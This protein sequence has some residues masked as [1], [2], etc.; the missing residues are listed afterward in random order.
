MKIKH[1]LF[2][3]VWRKANQFKIMVVA[4]I[5]LLVV[6]FMLYNALI[7]DNFIYAWFDLGIIGWAMLLIILVA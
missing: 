1:K 7:H 6:P 4:L 2:S 3:A 5:L